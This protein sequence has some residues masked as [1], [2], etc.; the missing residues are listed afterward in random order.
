MEEYYHTRHSFL[1]RLSRD[2]S[3]RKEMGA[4]IGVERKMAQLSINIQFLKRS[5]REFCPGR[6]LAKC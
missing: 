5:V 3:L 2:V 1:Q 6:K 4:L